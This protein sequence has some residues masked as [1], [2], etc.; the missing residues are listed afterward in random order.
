MPFI[1]LRLAQ[2][3]SKSP[4]K[5]GKKVL[6]VHSN[7]FRGSQSAHKGPHSHATASSSSSHSNRSHRHSQPITPPLPLSQMPP[8]HASPSP[9]HNGALPD[10]PPPLPSPRNRMKPVT[11]PVAPKSFP[12][13]TTTTTATSSQ[14]LPRPTTDI[15][16]RQLP[17][18][19]GLVGSSSDP[20][21][22][23][24]KRPPAPL[25]NNVGR[26]C[27]WAW[28]AEL[29]CN[30]FFHVITSLEPRL[31]SNASRY[32]LYEH[33]LSFTS[34]YIYIRMR[35]NYL[36]INSHCSCPRV[37]TLRQGLNNLPSTKIRRSFPKIVVGSLPT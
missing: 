23:I 30:G 3:P 31:D 15:Q 5:V 28:R 2:T 18:I 25:P 37:I 36:H 13:A 4:P 7:E 12:T 17:G 21:L 24:D 16:S 32:P 20:S 8:H 6:R 1:F 9:P 14:T 35:E 33:L 10:V 22:D 27:A 19:P 26:F 11:P 34:A 29:L